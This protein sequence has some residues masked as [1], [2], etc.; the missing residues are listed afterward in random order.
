MGHGTRAIR[1]GAPK[2]L[3][4]QV[5]RPLAPVAWLLQ[6]SSPQA[7]RGLAGNA[8]DSGRMSNVMR[9]RPAFFFWSI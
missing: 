5:C 6:R 3:E 1:R 2:Y 4:A 8:A 7:L 9:F